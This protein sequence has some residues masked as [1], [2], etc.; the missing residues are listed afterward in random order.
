MSMK[1]IAAWSLRH[2]VIVV[3]LWVL[4][5]IVG[6]ASVGP[7]TKKLNP[8]FSSP[9]H[10]SYRANQELARKFGNG[11]ESAPLIAVVTLPGH[12]SVNSP[13]VLSG[14][15]SAEQRIKEVVPK[16]RIASYATTNHDPA[17]VSRDGRITFIVAYPPPEANPDGNSPLAAMAVS[18]TLKHVTVGGGTFHVTGIDAL[19]ASAGQTTGPSILV[20]S[21]VGGLGAL[22]VLVFVFASFLAILPLLIAFVS[23]MAS[24]LVLLGLTQFTSISWLVEI[25]IAFVGLGIAIDY[26]LLV[27]ARWRE[28]R[29]HGHTGDEAVVRAIQTAG[30]SVVFSGSAV[31]IGLLALIAIPV[32]FLRSVGY[33]GMIIPLVTVVATITFLPI[34]LATVGHW[35]DWP[36]IHT[37][38]N[39]SKSWE[40]WAHFVVRFRWAAVLV[41]LLILGFLVGAATKLTLG[42]ANGDPTILSQHGEA[43]TGLTILKQSSIGQGVLTPIEIVTSTQ[44]ATQLASKLGSH[45]SADLQGVMAPLGS[46]WNNGATTVVDVFTHNNLPATLTEMRTAAHTADSASLVGGIDAK[47]RDFIA[48]TY[49]N[50]PTVIIL[51]SIFTFILLT[52]AFRSALLSF[53]AVLLNIVSLF[54]AWGAMVLVW[55]MGY[56]SHALWGISATGSIP[57]WLPAIIFAILFGISMD[58]GVFIVSR[59]HEE[60]LAGGAIDSAVA[61]GIARTGRLVTSAALI[62]FLAFLSMSTAPSTPIKIVATG[63][64]AGLILDATVIRALLLPALVSLSGKWIGR[65]AKTP[66][67]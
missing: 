60:F 6:I 52:R 59:I 7:A 18:K 4:L 48:D 15:R 35:L 45:K 50:F 65:K 40:K 66:I 57:S 56:G 54:S 25:L 16:A 9:G 49:S 61:T 26:S 8:Q 19:T 44:H 27:V 39:A 34:I 21:I 13:N 41:S 29:A 43:K 28:E 46:D 31:A 20:E 58:Y 37:D 67:K 42:P 22:V 32:P 63:L 17:F 3:G 2:K 62:M 11:G 51:L 30:H 10:E 23:I 24:F 55:Q 38:K 47:N 53:E 5:T 14:L 12:V 33:G 36:H 64:G 1:S